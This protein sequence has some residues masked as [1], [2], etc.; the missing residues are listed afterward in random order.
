MPRGERRKQDWSPRKKLRMFQIV[1]ISEDDSPLIVY[2]RMTGTVDILAQYWDRQSSWRYLVYQ[3][4]VEDDAIRDLP[5]ADWDGIAEAIGGSKQQLLWD[6]RSQDPVER[7]WVYQ[8]AGFH[9]GFEKLDQH[10]MEKRAKDLK[11]IG[12]RR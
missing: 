3:W 5:W 1:H 2:G 12:P 11:E 8:A 10:P 4:T 7:A 9:H 6:G